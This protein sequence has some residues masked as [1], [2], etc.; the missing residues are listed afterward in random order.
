MAFEAGPNRLDDSS[1]CRLE[2]VVVAGVIHTT[3]SSTTSTTST[4]IR[5]PKAQLTLSA[6]GHFRNSSMRPHRHQRHLLAAAATLCCLLA[7]IVQPVLSDDP[8]PPPVSAS[9]PTILPRT[10]R[11][12]QPRQ[13]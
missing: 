6:F 13:P 2:F 8:P 7:I 5:K 1:I 12:R 3:T 10:P 11:S 4:T 9:G